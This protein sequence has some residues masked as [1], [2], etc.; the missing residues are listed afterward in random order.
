M[1][2]RTGALVV[3]LVLLGLLPPLPWLAAAATVT[4]TDCGDTGGPGQLR[5]L[6][7]NNNA[8]AGGDV[9]NVPACMITLTTPPSPN[10]LTIN[11]SVTINGAGAQNTII[12]GGNITQIVR[13]VSGT[14][15]VAISGLTLQKGNGSLGGAILNQGTL[16]LTNVVITANTASEGGG[17]NGN[18][19]GSQTLINSTVSGNTAGLGG[20]L[21]LIGPLTLINTTVTGNTSTAISG[22]GGVASNGNP[23]II[24]STI[25]GNHALAGNGGGIKTFGVAVRLR[26]TIIAG[27]TALSG[28][29]CSGLFTSDGNNLESANTCSLDPILDFINTDPLLGPLQLNGGPTPTHALLPGSP[30]I[31]AGNNLGCPST[32]QRGVPRPL[33]GSNSGLTVCDIG[34]FE[35][36]TLGF[37]QASL[38]LNTAG[39]R[40]GTFLQGTVSV[41]NVGGARALDVYVVLVPP[42]SAGPSLGC[43]SGGALAFL[44]GSGATLT[45]VSSGVQTFAPQLT[46]VSLPADLFTAVSAPV[47][48]FTWPATAPTGPWTAAVVL[49]PVGAFKDGRVN[50]M[51]GIVVAP[52]AF[53]ATP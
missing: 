27:N 13:V 39:V 45:C 51:A 20:G 38:S 8:G 25:T 19:G 9:I 40:P 43:P 4:V 14:P 35:V 23:L 7:N 48:S 44:T 21:S 26:N 41:T 5:T 24:N 15:G 32:D 46:D 49:T 18:S 36:E 28:A 52:A 12:D 42:A 50:P 29:N 37:I 22:G 3:T 6:I 53:S 16:T 47:F 30:A 31:D 10:P 33:D 11:K 34:A 17:I 1:K 2:T